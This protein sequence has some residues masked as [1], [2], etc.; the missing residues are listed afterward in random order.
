MKIVELLIVLDLDLAL[1][2]VEQVGTIQWKHGV[3]IFS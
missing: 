3:G 1:V 2:K